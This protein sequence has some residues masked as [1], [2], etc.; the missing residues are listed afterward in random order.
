[1]QKYLVSPANGTGSKNRKSIWAQRWSDRQKIQFN[2][3]E[4]E[5]PNGI[6]VT[7]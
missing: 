6:A 1:M 7:L 2:L 5:S 4:F 3:P